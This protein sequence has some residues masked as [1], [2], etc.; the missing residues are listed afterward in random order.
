M[1]ISRYPS[2]KEDETRTEVG[3]SCQHERERDC[4]HPAQGIQHSAPRHWCATSPPFDLALHGDARKDEKYEHDWDRDDRDYELGC[5]VL[6]HDNDQLP[7]RVNSLGWQ[8]R[9][10]DMPAW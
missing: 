7:A 2:E 3:L 5:V 8:W 4:H 10:A 6:Q 9:G 1:S